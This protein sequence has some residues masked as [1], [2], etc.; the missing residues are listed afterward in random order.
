MTADAYRAQIAL[1]H[2]ISLITTPLATKVEQYKSGNIATQ[3]GEHVAKKGGA[4]FVG[5]LFNECS[6]R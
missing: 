2:A 5:H 3:N 1:E 6:E 4:Q